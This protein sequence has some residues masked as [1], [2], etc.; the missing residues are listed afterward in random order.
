MT[1]RWFK[2]LSDFDAY[3]TRAT[4]KCALLEC[5]GDNQLGNPFSQLKLLRQTT[6]IDGY[7]EAFE[8][9]TVQVP[10]LTEEQYMGLFL[11]G[12]R[13]D[14]RL[15]VLAFEPLNR[16]D[17]LGLLLKLEIQKLVQNHTNIRQ[18]YL[19]GIIVIV[20]G[21]EWYSALISL[22]DLQELRM[23]YCNMSGP[24]ARCFPFKTLNL[25]F[26]V[27]DYNNLSSPQCQKHLHV[28]KI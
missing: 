15:K 4:F 6:I 22:H 20:R 13:K 12:L 5:Y 25:S 19:D 10:L 14:I 18:L 2:V 8:I 3:L 7:V 9:L 21:H 23:S 11:G 1:W 16:Q 24:L 27:L 17:S 26:I 28:R